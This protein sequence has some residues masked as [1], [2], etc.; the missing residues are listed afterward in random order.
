MRFRS[1]LR[2]GDP[3]KLDRWCDEASRSGID[4]LRRSAK[5]LQRDRNA[6]HNAPCTAAPELTPS[7]KA[8][9]P[10]VNGYP[11]DEEEPDY[12]RPTGAKAITAYTAELNP[13]NDE[14]PSRRASRFVP[15]TR[16]MPGRLHSTK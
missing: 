14:P 11:E 2:S 7:G 15:S 6:V 1:T 13:R 9:S 3:E 8:A 4:V 5:V 10:L 16:E 12:G